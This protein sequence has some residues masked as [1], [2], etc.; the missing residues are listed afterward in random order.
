MLANA[1]ALG[2]VKLVPRYFLHGPSEQAP[3]AVYSIGIADRSALA[4]KLSRAALRQV[5]GNIV[6]A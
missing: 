3:I 2:R 6:G 1:P 4:A 5:A